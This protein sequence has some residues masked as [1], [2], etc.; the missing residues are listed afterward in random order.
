MVLYVRKL[1]NLSNAIKYGI[2]QKPIFVSLFAKNNEV[3]LIFANEGKEI[4]NKEVIFE[5]FKRDSTE[6]FGQGIGLN[7]VK[8]ICEKYGIK[9]KVTYENNQNKFIYTFSNKLCKID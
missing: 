5:R 9:T 1:C 8:E 7:L 2:I 6:S 3:V 4:K